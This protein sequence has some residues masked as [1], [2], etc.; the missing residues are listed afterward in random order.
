MNPLAGGTRYRDGATTY[1]QFRG[2]R[3]NIEIENP[4]EHHSARYRRRHPFK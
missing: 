3:Y 4:F 2:R 1:N